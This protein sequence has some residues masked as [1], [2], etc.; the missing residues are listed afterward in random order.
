MPTLEILG[1]KPTRLILALILLPLLSIFMVSLGSWQLRRAAEKQTMLTQ[2]TQAAAHPVQRFNAQQL[3]A[4]PSD[5][6]RYRRIL[7]RGSWIADKG[8]FIDNRIHQGKPGYWLIMPLKL[9]EPSESNLAHIDTAARA[10]LSLTTPA[11]KPTAK[12]AVRPKPPVIVLINRGWFPKQLGQTPQLNNIPTST[13]ELDLQGQVLD[14]LPRFISLESTPNTPIGGVWQNFSVQR[15]Q[16]ISGLNTLAF[17]V[18]QD[19]P[20]NDGLLQDTFTPTLDPD[21]NRGYAY[22][23]FSFAAIA[24]IAF[25]I[26][27]WQLV[28]VYFKKPSSRGE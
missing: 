23:W 4:T 27:C 6:L 15:Y 8:V 28:P 11:V 26:L 10:R 25:L 12:P 1:L 3:A 14:H 9:S 20:S 16:E 24:G 17:I 2:I 13:V 22:Q 19:Q 18:Q 7:I 5:N 21:K